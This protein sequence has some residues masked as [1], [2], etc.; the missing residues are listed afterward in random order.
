M[1]GKHELFNDS[2]RSAG[3]WY[4]YEQMSREGRRGCRGET[5]ASSA[6]PYSNHSDSE[7]FRRK[8]H[9]AAGCVTGS[10]R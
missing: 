9:D 10:G 8:S 7:T 6:M 4:L 3:G 5:Y 1:I 2:F